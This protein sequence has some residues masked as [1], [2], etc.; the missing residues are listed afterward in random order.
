M[1]DRRVQDLSV[2]ATRS[3]RITALAALLA[4]LPAGTAQNE[5]DLRGSITGVT[6]AEERALRNG[7]QGSF[8]VRASSGADA[9]VTVMD[10]TKIYLQQ[11]K[12]RRPASFDALKPGLTVEVRFA[13]PAAQS[14]P[15][16]ATA[17]EVLI[18]SR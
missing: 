2:T 6:K 4:F 1:K 5:W 17:A 7:V 10:S 9:A 16:Q 14:Y 8:L 18:L 13:G 3:I 15:V 11:A 12:D